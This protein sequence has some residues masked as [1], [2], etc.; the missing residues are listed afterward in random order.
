M[1]IDKVASKY[2]AWFKFLQVNKKNKKGERIK[3][4]LIN[5]ATKETC[6]TIK[7]IINRYV[8]LT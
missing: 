6:I 2:I 7:T 1:P 8:K 5:V 3:Y 4:M